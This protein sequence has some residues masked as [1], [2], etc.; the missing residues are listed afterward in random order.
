M[1]VCHVCMSSLSGFEAINLETSTVE[2]LEF[3]TGA[4]QL[5]ALPRGEFPLRSELRFSGAMHLFH[6]FGLPDLP[7]K[8]QLLEA[9]DRLERTG[10]LSRRGLSRSRAEQSVHH[11]LESFRKQTAARAPETR[12]SCALPSCGA[13]EAHAAH[14]KRCAACKSVVYCCREH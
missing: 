2:L 4:V 8:Q 9:W 3:S 1:S 5:L 6:T 11:V 14:F 10:V 12:L 7:A 13:P